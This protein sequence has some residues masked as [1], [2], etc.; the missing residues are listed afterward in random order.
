M[1]PAGWSSKA[2]CVS[3]LCE[4]QGVCVLYLGKDLA[5]LDACEVPL[6]VEGCGQV[7]EEHADGAHAVIKVVQQAVNLATQAGVRGWQVCERTKN[8]TS[9]SVMGCSLALRTMPAAAAAAAGCAFRHDSCLSRLGCV[10]CV[11]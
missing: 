11:V 6:L 7:G 8:Q 4:L 9:E 1:R 5:Q 3:T 2:A 10:C